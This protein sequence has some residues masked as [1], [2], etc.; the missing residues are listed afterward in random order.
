MT[1]KTNAKN[2]KEEAEITTALLQELDSLFSQPIKAS[3]T[4]KTSR[5]AA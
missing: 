5:K 4:R 2:K 1:T 3:R